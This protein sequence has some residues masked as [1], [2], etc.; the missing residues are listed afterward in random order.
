MNG[1]SIN[2]N[3][4]EYG[5]YATETVTINGGS[6]YAN[7]YVGG[8]YTFGTI[9]VNGGSIHANGHNDGMRS[10]NLS[11]NGGKVE[12]SSIYSVYDIS[13]GWTN[14]DDYIHANYY[15]NNYGAVFVKSGQSFYYEYGGEHVIVS[16]T[17]DFEQIS[18]IMGK[19]LRPRFVNYMDGEGEMHI[20]TDYTMLTGNET[21]LD[22]GWYAVDSDITYHSNL[23]IG[24]DVNLI[25]CN[26]KTMTLGTDE[27]G[28]GGI[29][30]SENNDGGNLIVY[31]QCL[32]PEVAGT[33][34]ADV[35]RFPQ[36]ESGF[37]Y[38]EATP[39]G[40]WNAIRCQTTPNTAAMSLPAIRIGM[41]SKPATSRLTAAVFMPTDLR[42]AFLHI[43]SPS[44]AAA[45][46]LTEEK[47][48]VSG[49]MEA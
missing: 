48:M 19:T 20:C 14:T 2:A 49:P 28:N 21:T 29:K 1:G 47:R 34:N 18:A 6:I 38:R 43:A 3:G 22:A 46:M 41:P 37:N 33:L 7:G 11:I 4:S 13:L 25:L 30:S 35:N 8:I 40:E 5:A 26:G 17:L 44:V 9:T 32:I 23:T 15:V 27:I 36:F 10:D 12:A 42:M 31:G 45:S 24:G 16:D 39:T